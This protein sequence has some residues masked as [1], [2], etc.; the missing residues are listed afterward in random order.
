MGK[1]MQDSTSHKTVL[2][3][4]DDEDI[5]SLLEDQLEMLGHKALTAAN[6]YECLKQVKT[7]KPDLII[8]DIRMPLMDGITTLKHLKADQ[9]QIPVVIYSGYLDDDTIKL[10]DSLGARKAYSK[11]FTQADLQDAIARY[12][13]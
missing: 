3:V 13:P 1:A 11:P 12:C 8:M 5:R 4:D 9:V 10:S 6:G 7:S 2:V